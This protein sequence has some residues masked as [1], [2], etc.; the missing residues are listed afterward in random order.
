PVNKCGGTDADDSKSKGMLSIF[1][2]GFLGGLIGLIMPCT[3]PMIPLTVSF[4][5][6]RSASR[7][8]GI[9]NAFLYGF[10]IF[11]IYVLISVP[12][13]F[14]KSNSANILN[15]I[16]TNIWLNLVFATVFVAFALS[17][18]GLFEITLPSSI[19]NS[20]DSKANM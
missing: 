14:L 15:D 8:K 20:V 6:K 3:F 9:A 17:F 11:I 13:Y 16:S 7:K 18:F 1:I 5:T 2:L 10:F 4:F 19:S 12:F